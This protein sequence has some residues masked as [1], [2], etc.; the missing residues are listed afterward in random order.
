MQP[1]LQG[2]IYKGCQENL[3]DV[4]IISQMFHEHFGNLWKVLRTCQRSCPK[5]SMEKC[6]LFKKEVQ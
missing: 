4:I 3:D 5:L 2:L 6:W 1:I